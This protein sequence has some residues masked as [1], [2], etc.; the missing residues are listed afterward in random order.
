MTTPG[1]PNPHGGLLT[2]QVEAV[3]AEKQVE[4]IRTYDAESNFRKLAGPVGMLVTTLAVVLSS[5]HIYTA[6][7]GL[8]DEIKH[9]WFH[10]SLVLALIFLVFPRQRL[11]AEAARAATAW[12]WSVAFAA[13]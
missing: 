2:D 8:L 3:S 9:R 7:F 13:F 6:G 11:P 5:F 4:L 10:L 12:G 1:T